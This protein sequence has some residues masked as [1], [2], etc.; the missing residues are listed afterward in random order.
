MSNIAVVDFDPFFRKFIFW[1]GYQSCWSD[2]GFHKKALAGSDIF[3]NFDI[4]VL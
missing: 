1:L 2:F 3:Y 4:I